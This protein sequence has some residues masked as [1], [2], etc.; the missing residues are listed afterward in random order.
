MNLKFLCKNKWGRGS[1]GRFEDFR[2]KGTSGVHELRDAIRTDL[3]QNVEF[4]VYASAKI[5]SC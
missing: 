4:P 1:F 3:K 2:G 5:A